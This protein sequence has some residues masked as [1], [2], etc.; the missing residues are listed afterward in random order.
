M[1]QPSTSQRRW[2]KTKTWLNLLNV[3]LQGKLHTGVDIFAVYKFE[4][5]HEIL[6]VCMLCYFLSNFAHQT[7]LLSKGVYKSSPVFDSSFCHQRE[8]S[9]LLLRV[10][11]VF[12][13]E[14]ISLLRFIVLITATR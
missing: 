13:V 1:D 11:T 2:P 8:V 10:L 9:I 14:G 5:Q 6:E 4:E 3:R 12:F 7:T